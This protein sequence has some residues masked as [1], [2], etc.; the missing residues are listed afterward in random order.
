MLHDKRSSYLDKNNKN[1]KPLF[2]IYFGL[3]NKGRMYERKTFGF[4]DMLGN[5]GGVMEFINVAN[6]VIVVFL[7][8]TQMNINYIG[9]FRRNILDD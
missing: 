2:I 4:F 5:V 8:T 1:H 6:G 9:I 3:D 7:C